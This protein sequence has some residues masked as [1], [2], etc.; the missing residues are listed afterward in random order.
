MTIIENK[1]AE[2]S[3]GLE[4][5]ETLQMR[6][7][8]VY[9]D[10]PMDQIPELKESFCEETTQ[11]HRQFSSQSNPLVPKAKVGSEAELRLEDTQL[12]SQQILD[13]YYG[14]GRESPYVSAYQKRVT[15]STE[16]R[17]YKDQVSQVS[18][19]PQYQQVKAKHSRKTS[20]DR[21]E[22][23]SSLQDFQS[24]SHQCAGHR[25]GAS[26]GQNPS[27]KQS[28][29]SE[30]QPFRSKTSK[31]SPLKEEP[32][33]EAGPSVEK[34]RQNQI[35]EYILDAKRDTQQQSFVTYGSATKSVIKANF[36][37]TPDK[38]EQFTVR[39]ESLMFEQSAQDAKYAEYYD[40]CQD[41]KPQPTQ[42]LADL[43]DYKVPE[44]K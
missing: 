42:G 28:F 23:Q 22:P 30:E 12:Q 5:E 35:I 26:I 4:E 32:A 40:F 27:Q 24:L 21:S 31:N 14:V 34:S 25:R 18:E 11:S 6:E 1:V 3:S 20:L 10:L 7:R 16:V 39:K 37:K 17:E 9:I 8:K 44:K 38:N 2:E 13:S 33:E 41:K 43:H 19:L 36:G 29:E 15:P